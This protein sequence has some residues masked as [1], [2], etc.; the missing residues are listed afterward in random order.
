MLNLYLPLVATPVSVWPL[1][2][3]CPQ[4]SPT[5]DGT[6]ISSSGLLLLLLLLLLC[7]LCQVHQWLRI[8]PCP[9]PDLPPATP[10]SLHLHTPSALALTQVVL[11]PVLDIA[12]DL[13]LVKSTSNPYLSCSDLVSLTYLSLHLLYCPCNTSSPFLLLLQFIFLYLVYFPVCF[14]SIPCLNI[15]ALCKKVDSRTWLG[16]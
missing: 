15:T 8:F 13:T 1:P 2:L 10:P 16:V 6:S 3:S 4:P 7:F 11:P 5:P 9:T 14:C 12:L